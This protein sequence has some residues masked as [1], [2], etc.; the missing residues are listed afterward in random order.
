MSPWFARLFAVALVAQLRPASAEPIELDL[1]RALARAHRAAPDAIAAR[2]RIAQA[3]AAV[4]GADVAFESN[5]ALEGGAGLRL[6][7]GH[8]TDADVRIEQ[9]LEPGR[10]GPRRQL[11]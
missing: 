1:P 7:P 9:N 6:G 4:I 5:L 11:A 3:D 8:P 2:G 10:R